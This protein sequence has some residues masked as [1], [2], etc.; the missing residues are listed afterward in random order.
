MPIVEI[1]IKRQSRFPIS[2]HSI[3]DGS[4]LRFSVVEICGGNDDFFTSNPVH[5]L[6]QQECVGASSSSLV[7]L[8]PR[9]G[10]SFSVDIQCSVSNENTLVTIDW[11][12]LGSLLTVE[13]QSQFMLMWSSLGTDDDMT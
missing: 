13:S 10:T 6:F 2:S 7:K 5:N 3:G 8:G 9:L 12:L 1:L 11:Q 4:Y